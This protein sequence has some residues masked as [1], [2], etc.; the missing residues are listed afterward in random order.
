MKKGLKIIVVIILL[1]VCFE[2]IQGFNLN[3]FKLARFHEGK[4]KASRDSNVKYNDEWSYKIESQDYNDYMLYKT[5]EVK[6][7]TA[8]KVSC[9]VKTE[10]VQAE[11]KLG[12]GF[13][14]GLKDTLEKSISIY[15][16][17]DWT[18]LTFYFNSKNNESVDIAF[19]LGDNSQ[20]CKGTVWFSDMN[21]E[22]GRQRK[23]ANWNFAVFMINNTQLEVEGQ[24]ISEQLSNPQENII[25]NSFIGFKETL[26]DFTNNDIKVEYDIINIDKPLTRVS[27]DPESGYYISR[28]D[29][30][31][32]IN[33][34]IY[35][36]KQYDHIFVVANIGDKI[37]TDELE[38]IGLGGMLYDNIGYSNIRISDESMR[39]YIT[40]YSN[41]FPE[42][43]ILHEFLHTLERNSIR[44]GYE[45][46]ALHDYKKYGY[47]NDAKYGQKDWY[48]DYI[49]NRIQNTD[50]GIREEVFYTQPVSNKNFSKRDDITEIL[51][52]SENFIQ[53]ISEKISKI[54]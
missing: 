35:D 9:M 27:Y 41:Y 42:E 38:W 50:N 25:E 30:Y 20:N 33:E 8:Y 46:I 13:N 7:N 34:Y 31:E 47:R 53:R 40:S 1:I 37:S 2:I 21:L 45:T 19:R 10:N 36:K 28:E 49:L 16:T 3:G 14:I 23:T 12:G 44:L 18:E 5:I 17:N 4:T 29:S 26:E 32:L 22:I 54:I 15:G 24:K 39:A 6:K 48:R 43:V 11:E 51:N 52:K